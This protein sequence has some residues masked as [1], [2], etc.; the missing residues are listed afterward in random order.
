MLVTKLWDVKV[1]GHFKASSFKHNDFTSQDRQAGSRKS[2]LYTVDC[3]QG[4]TANW[5]P[6][7]S[8]AQRLRVIQIACRLVS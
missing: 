6:E 3:T 4:W 2:D 8:G 7:P 1:L 5:A